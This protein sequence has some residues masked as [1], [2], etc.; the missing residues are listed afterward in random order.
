MEDLNTAYKFSKNM[1]VSSGLSE[2]NIK[3]INNTLSQEREKLLA[4]INVI[5][6]I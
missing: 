2:A 1:V 5:K 6:I 3:Y 4:E